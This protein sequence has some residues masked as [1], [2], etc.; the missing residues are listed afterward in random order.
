MST[1]IRGFGLGL[2]PQHYR[3]FIDARPAV[4]WLEVLTENYMVPGGKPLA[5]LE[6]IR[7]DYPVVMHGVSMSIGGCDP[8]DLR[9]L[10]ELKALAQRLEP[11][12]IS[13]HVCWTSMDGHQVHDLLPM[14]HTQA[15][16]AHLVQRVQRVQDVLGRRL[17]LENV[18]SYVRFRCD[19]MSEWEFLAELARRADCELLL[20]VTNVY[21]NSRNHG[22]SARDFLDALPVQRVRQ[23]H[24]AGHED[25]GTHL[26]DTHDRPVCESVWSLYRHAATRFGAVP[27][28]IERDAEIPPL[29]DLLAELDR[30]RGIQADL[31]RPLPQALMA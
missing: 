28:M 1:S 6:A 12:W 22:F 19:E 2:R 15:A 14:P 5:M 20:D 7:V 31:T 30:A 13:D 21:V 27:T 26:V 16:L 24:L 10:N 8:L 25:Q 9:Y 3:D 17:V 11:A 23:I 18:S 29:G 4:D